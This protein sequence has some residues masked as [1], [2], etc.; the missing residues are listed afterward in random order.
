MNRKTKFRVWD[1][2]T[3]TFILPGKGYQ[4]HYILDLNGNFHNL[5]NGSGSTDHVVQ[6]FTGMKDRNDKEIYEGDVLLENMTEEMAFH[7]EGSSID[8]VKFISGAFMIECEPLHN[9]T[10]SATPDIIEDYVVIGNIFE[11]KELLK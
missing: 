11:N 7:G 1:T 6:Q 8:V 5:Q 3:K 4:G 9:Y 10:Y 2:L